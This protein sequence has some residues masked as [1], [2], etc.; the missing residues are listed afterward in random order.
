MTQSA[1]EARSNIRERV[2]ERTIALFEDALVWDMT[3][4]W[5]PS[6]ADKDI[7]LPRFRNVGVDFASLTVNDFPG[8]L[9]G[10]VRRIAEVTRHIQERADT[11]VLAKSVDDILQAKREGK[12]ALAF[13]LQE[14]N[15]LEGEINFVQTYYDLGGNH[16]VV[17]L[18]VEGISMLLTHRAEFSSVVNRKGIDGLLSDIRARI[19][20]PRE[21]AAE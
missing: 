2:S 6:Y 17:D 21:D 18:Y 20:A 14:T 7:T 13:N 3:L 12:L 1:A 9:G 19:E 5:L 16:T 8:S 15:P 10:S 4:P 11:M